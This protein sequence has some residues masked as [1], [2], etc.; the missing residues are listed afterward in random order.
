MTF[1]NLLQLR[2]ALIMTFVGTLYILQAI[3]SYGSG[4]MDIEELAEV[5]RC[6]LPGSGSCGTEY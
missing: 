4:V 1:K 2:F 3:G 5:E 6:S